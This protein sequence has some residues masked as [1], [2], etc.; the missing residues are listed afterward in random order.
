MPR[1]GFE[2]TT[3]MFERAKTVHALDLAVSVIGLLLSTVHSSVIGFKPVTSLNI[4]TSIH[5]DVAAE[6]I[7]FL[8]GT[9]S[10]PDPGSY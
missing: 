1:V 2:P 7:S 6:W 8:R 4:V 5:S 10:N 3:S 9:G